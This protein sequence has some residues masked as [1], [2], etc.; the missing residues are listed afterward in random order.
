MEN[1]VQRLPKSIDS[2][3]FCTTNNPSTFCALLVGNYSC[4][5][6]PIETFE[7]LKLIISTWLPLEV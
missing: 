3:T 2:C 6:P 4:L 7:T 5:Y 1:K